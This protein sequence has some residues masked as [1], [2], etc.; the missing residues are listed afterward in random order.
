MEEG[1]YNLA[2][3]RA[4]LSSIIFEPEQL[5]DLAVALREQD[6]YLPTHSDIFRTI[7]GLAR[8]DMPIDEEFIRQRLMHEGK[9]DEGAM[10]AIL[11]ATPISNVSAYVQQL[12]EKAQHR[13]LMTMTTTI[14]QRVLEEHMAPDDIIGTCSKEME[15]ISDAGMTSERG[16]DAFVDG[17]RAEFAAASQKGAQR[18]F[19]SGNA[20]LDHL[21]GGFE[22]G[23]LVVIGARPSMGK[24]AL[25]VNM[26]IHALES[27]HGVYFDS[28]EMPGEKLMRRLVACRSGE[29][30]GDLK[31][32]VCRS[33]ERVNAAESF[34]RTRD[35]VLRDTSYITISQLRARFKREIRRNPN[36]KYWFIDHLRYIKRP[37]KNR[38]DLEV[39]EITNGFTAF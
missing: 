6:F 24:T 14:R 16:T 13:A 7:L 20:A 36:I 17:F 3:E 30:I 25:A 34:F 18:L 37:G 19:Y 39:S 23:T 28:L 5:Q 22:P 26:T 10:V 4:V 33:P 32:G 27:G 21:V 12:R 1:L 11:S 9:F 8:D 35:F 29:S 2:F 31:H 38:D 15:E